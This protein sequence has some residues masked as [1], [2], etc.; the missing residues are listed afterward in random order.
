MRLTYAPI[1]VLPLFAA[2]ALVGCGDSASDQPKTVAEVVKE[3]A[4]MDQPEPG[5]YRSSI[6]LLEYATPGLPPQEADRM[7][8]MMEGHPGEARE[9]CLTPE[10]AKGGFEEMFKKTQ[11]GKCSF[12]KFDASANTID[13]K[14]TCETS[15]GMKST[16]AM[17]GSISAKSSRMEMEMDQA[18]P[19]VPGGKVH[20][21]MQV[22]N[23][24]IGDC[25][26]A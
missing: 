24:R 21:K 11:Q 4:K 19:G 17:K 20:M 14:M 10:D 13:A 12:E 3:A 22:A 16:I 18:N 8:Q 26:K 15:P 6:K 9:F 25:P 5:L 7:K 1:H 2:F 23:E